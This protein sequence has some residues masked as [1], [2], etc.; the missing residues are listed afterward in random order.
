MERRTA[1]L[2]LIRQD[3]A[4]CTV[5][6]TSRSSGPRYA[7]PLNSGVRLPRNL[8]R[9]LVLILKIGRDLH[10]HQCLHDGMSSGGIVCGEGIFEQCQRSGTRR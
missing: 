1:S 4:A 6:L 7:R 9:R 5:R 2:N 10:S 8:L 3:C